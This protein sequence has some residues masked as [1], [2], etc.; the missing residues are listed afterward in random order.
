LDGAGQ[1]LGLP[2]YRTSHQWTSSY[3]AN[4]TLTCTSLVDSEVDLI[5]RIVQA[6]ATIRQ[7]PDI[8]ERKH[9]TLLPCFRLCI[10]VGDH[11]FEHLL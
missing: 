5:A 3:G 9:Q 4:K 8:F 1:W 6:A 7:Q 11:I 2:G 10:E